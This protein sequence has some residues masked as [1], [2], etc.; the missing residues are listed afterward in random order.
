VMALVLELF[1][2]RERPFLNSYFFTSYCNIIYLFTDGAGV[3]RLFEVKRL[4]RSLF[5]KLLLF[6]TSYFNLNYLFKNG[7][8]V[9]RLLEATGA[10]SVVNSTPT[11]SHQT[12]M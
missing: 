9:G 7:A 8:G 11:F 5:L 6:F 12:I 4:E 2:R 10:P 3:G 1:E